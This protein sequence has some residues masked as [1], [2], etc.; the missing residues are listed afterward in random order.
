MAE[1]SSNLSLN[2]TYTELYITE[3]GSGEVNREH[4]IIELECTRCTNEEKK[5]HL[6]DIFNALPNEKY[7]QKRVLTK[8]IAGIGKT[9]AVQKFTLDWADGKANHLFHFVF[10]F[11]FRDLNLINE[12][13]VSLIDLIC[14]YF[15][16]VQDL[17]DSV[18]KQSNLL[19]IFDGLDES[20]YPLN[21]E[22]NAMCRSVT[23]TTTVD[24]I[25]T[26][27]FKGTLLPKAS[28][29]ITTR[30]AAANK[31]PPNC[32]N[33]VTEVRGF[34]DEQKEEY[35]R[36]NIGD[37]NVAQRILDHLLSKPLRSLYI[38]CHIPIFCWISA[39]AL[40][41]LLSNQDQNELPKTLTEMYMHFLI[42]QTELKKQKDYHG[43]DPDKDMVMKLGKLA[44]EQLEKGNIIF[45]EEDLKECNI[46]LKQAAVYSGVC[47]QII[48]KESGLHKKVVYSFIH[49]S[50]QEFLAALYVHKTFV[51]HGENLL[52]KKTVKVV[53]V[54]GESPV[55]FLHKSAVDKALDSDYGQWDLFLRFLL[56][57]SQDKN[58][59]LLRKVFGAKDRLPQSREETIIYIH[60]KIEKMS[61]TNQ[62]INLFHCLNELGDQSLVEQVQR[63]YKLGD[64]SKILPAHW[65][66]LA[67]VL[68]VSNDDLSVFD[69]K[70]YHGS[71]AVLERLLPVLKASRTALLSECN[72]TDRCC[73]NI[74]SALT[75]KSGGLEVL[76]LSGNRLKDYGVEL[77]AESLKSP[78]CKLKGLRLKQCGMTTEG[79]QHLARCITSNPS[80]LRE[81][82]LSHNT[83]DDEGM[84]LLSD[85]LKTCCL[86][87]LRLKQC[88]ITTEGCQHLARCIASNPSYL[89]ELDLSKNKFHDE[90]MKLLSGVLRKCY[91][92]TLR[93]S[94]C[95]LKAKGCTD[96][97]SALYSNPSYLKN[98]DLS[99]NS[100]DRTSVDQLSDF[101]KHPDC[102]LQRLWLSE[103][104]LQRE[105]AA[106]LVSALNPIHL[107]EL[108]LGANQIGDAG[109]QEI[110][111]LLQSPH[112]KIEA[113]RLADCCFEDKGCAALLSS[114]LTNPAHLRV[115]DLEWN[116]F[117][118]ESVEKLSA[119]LENHSCQLETLKLAACRF[120]D[121][122]SAA[123]LSS[124]LTNPA[125]L[126]VLDLE[127]NII[128][129][130][131][132]E[133]LSAFLE[134]H[135]CQLEI[136]NLSCCFT[137]PD[138][139]K[140]LILAFSRCSF[141][142][143]LNLSYNPITSESL[144]LVC[145]WLSKAE[146]KLEVL[147]LSHVEEST[148]ELLAVALRSNPSH[149]KEL[150][151]IK[152][153]PGESGLKMLTDLQNNNFKLI[154]TD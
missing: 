70:K 14:D 151:L 65:S 6:N 72:L 24:V 28:V 140:P 74:S 63:F 123:L 68:L 106:V 116:Y 20:K 35:F 19:F 101:L 61:Y 49:L 56:G 150:E 36:K 93:V 108:D 114:L 127:R 80:H 51:E 57:L 50:V 22:N 120:K 1:E 146:C 126:R 73:S 10:P 3:G 69:L 125:H 111:A 37:K 48:R 25:L 105:G 12:K 104:N 144:K 90:G 143:E 38:M 154:L 33:I 92:E 30:P 95:G 89:R 147:R 102:Q 122:G 27:L 130:E 119:L 109:V 152:S 9:V 60:R 87:T 134:N 21:F 34:N 55:I 103:T 135:S 82:D 110:S 11:T 79:C 16:E 17:K 26:N 100:F 43:G 32:I 46:D 124:L 71:D 5:I 91:L 88:G 58:Q 75:M 113:L 66:A 18:Y 99:R 54:G 131:S 112:S 141:L 97:A 84:K 149:L 142:R 4:E 138:G 118:E 64:V 52:S 53:S 45:H 121:E 13:S 31:I 23:K 85:V 41:S 98:L 139:C 132:V 44:F 42:K 128:K 7:L 29:W 15:E 107:K 40:Q 133:K 2:K 59:E 81:L 96:L 76:D 94:E 136:L 62:G 115:L 137:T 39:T 148:C 78:N 47:T 77:L 86:D 129:E 145:D 83:F 153:H 117:K 67:F 8:G